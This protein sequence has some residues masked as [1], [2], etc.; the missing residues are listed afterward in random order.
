MALARLQTAGVICIE[1]FVDFPQMGRFTLRDEGKHDDL[2]NERY[3]GR[4]KGMDEWMD[5]RT[6]GW[7]DG[8]TDR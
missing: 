6:D 1:R 3:N 4:M 7:M 8:R 2:M 5:G